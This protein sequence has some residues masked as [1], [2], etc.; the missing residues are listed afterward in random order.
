MGRCHYR[1]LLVEAVG[2]VPRQEPNTTTTQ[3]LVPKMTETKKP[4]SIWSENISN[5]YLS[6]HSD[7]F[8]TGKPR[9]AL[10]G[11]LGLGV[12]VA[13]GSRRF[14]LIPTFFSRVHKPPLSAVNVHL[15]KDRISMA[16]QGYGFCEFLTE[17]DAEYACKIMNQ[18]KLWGKPI[19]VNKVRHRLSHGP[20]GYRCVPE[21]MPS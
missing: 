5:P 14:V 10:Y 12:D 18:I 15:P 8:L 1:S 6:Y 2:A 17:E 16:H 21:T 20:R 9:R 13:S 7:P 4:Q 3:C 19:R 11:C